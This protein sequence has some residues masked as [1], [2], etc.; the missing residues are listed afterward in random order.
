MTTSTIVAAAHGSGG[1]PTPITVLLVV[2]GVLYVM[3]RRLQGEPLQAKRLLALPIVFSVLGIF[4][5]TGSGT[6]LRPESVAF[7]VAGSLISFVLG[8]ARGATVELFSRDGHLWQRYRGVTV[9]L[10][11][12]VIA[13][14]LVLALVAHLVGAAGGTDVMLALGLSLAGEAALVAP[15]AL[16]TGVPFAPAPKRSNGDRAMGVGIDRFSAWGPIGRT[17]SDGGWDNRTSMPA[18]SCE[19][20]EPTDVR[21]WRSPTWRHGLD[22]LQHQVEP[23][24]QSDWSQ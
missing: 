2:A 6:R 3:W 15:R 4:D 11:G 8:A 20:N 24:E 21:P 22:W 17:P 7:L 13:S 9:A 5:L 1:I 14:K 19:T 10:W 16:S 18:S 12:A 23:P